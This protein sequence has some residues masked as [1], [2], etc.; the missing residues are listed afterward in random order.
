[1]W[2]GWLTCCGC[3]KSTVS[4]FPFFFF[5]PVSLPNEDRDPRFQMKPTIWKM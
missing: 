5:I 1:M 4:A 2:V 3:F